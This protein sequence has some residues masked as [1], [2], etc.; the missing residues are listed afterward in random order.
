ME[1]SLDRFVHSNYINWLT[2]LFM[3]N[4]YERKL[5]ED[6]WLNN[7]KL[8]EFFRKKKRK[9]W[10]FEESLCCLSR[11]QTVNE[12]EEKPRRVKLKSWKVGN[13]VLTKAAPISWRRTA[14]LVVNP[15]MTSRRR[16]HWCCHQWRQPS[17]VQ[18]LT[19]RGIPLTIC[20]LVA[21]ERSNLFSYW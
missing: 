2:S 11:K 6:L 12:E 19:V 1:P 13:H 4:S 16:L 7:R 14:Y 8:W 21:A 20:H 5:W 10:E 9:L 17:I 3:Q 18:L 15:L